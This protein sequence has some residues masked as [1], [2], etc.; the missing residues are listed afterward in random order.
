MLI[1][2]LAIRSAVSSNG[3]RA[4]ASPILRARA[5]LPVALSAPLAIVRLV[6]PPLIERFDVSCDPPASARISH[7]VEAGCHRAATLA[8][9]ARESMAAK[10]V[11]FSVYRAPTLP[12]HGAPTR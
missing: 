11:H 7:E 10:L 12:L 6:D 8:A 4:A 3:V 9:S 2:P 5:T 1:T